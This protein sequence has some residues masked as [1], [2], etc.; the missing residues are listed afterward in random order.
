M[1]DDVVKF[2]PAEARKSEPATFEIDVLYFGVTGDFHSRTKL[3]RPFR[4]GGDGKCFMP[5]VANY[6]VQI[7]DHGGPR[8]G[9]GTMPGQPPGSTGWPG[10]ILLRS[11]DGSFKLILSP[12]GIM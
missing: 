4:R 3:T 8:G 10:Y 12:Q 5:D 6:L 1:A 2:T 9:A 11:Q 7:R